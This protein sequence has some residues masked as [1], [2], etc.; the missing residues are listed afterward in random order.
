MHFS[1]SPFYSFFFSDIPG[2][3]LDREE[4]I[5]YNGDVRFEVRIPFFYIRV[6]R[7]LVSR[8]V[9]DQEAVGSN[10]ATRTIKN[11]LKPQWFQAVFLLLQRI[12][13]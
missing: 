12:P 3:P 2:K 13:N 1:L 4:I 9:R 11:S 6:W 8:L 5:L 10:P 7:S